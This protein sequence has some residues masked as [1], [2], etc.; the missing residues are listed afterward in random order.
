MSRM[1]LARIQ[2]RC[3]EDG[4]CLVW[5]GKLHQRTGSPAGTEWI[6]GRDAYVAIRRRAFEEYNRTKLT[7]GQEIICTCGNAACLEKTHLRK[8]SRS[9]RMR[10]MHVNMDAATKLR[11]NQSL[12]RAM[13]AQRGKLSP[14]AVEAIKNSPDGPYVTA[15]RLGVNGVIASRIKRGTSY[16]DYTRNPF[17]GLGA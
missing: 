10:L 3:T 9:E 5:T 8:V 4:D 16:K 2:A 14:E 13:Q 15:K 12:A 11:R 6:D 17:A 1:S 7:K